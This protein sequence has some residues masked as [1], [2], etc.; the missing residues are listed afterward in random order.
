M[1]NNRQPSQQGRNASGMK[2][3]NM[4]KCLIVDD[5]PFCGELLAHMLKD[6]FECSTATSGKEAWE[7][8]ELNWRNETPF[9]LIC[10]DLTMPQLSGHGL[11]RK[12]RSLEVTVSESEASP[13]KIIVVSGGMFSLDMGRTLLDDV[14]DGYLAKPCNRKELFELL[15]QNRLIEAHDI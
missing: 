14:A 4:K 7:S 15:L 12:I 2:E 8:I 9:D 3:I 6:H 1:G 11:I 13:S 5:E 10:C